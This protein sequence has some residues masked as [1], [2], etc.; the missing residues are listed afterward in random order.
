MTTVRSTAAQ[1]PAPLL[2]ATEKTEDR[3][4]D[5]TE[6]RFAEIDRQR[7]LDSFPTA[8]L[9]ASNGAFQRIMNPGLK[10]IQNDPSAANAVQRPLSTSN[11]KPPLQPQIY[12][13]KQQDVLV[14]SDCGQI[15]DFP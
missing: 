14:F 13:L 7:L 4:D 5:E 1:A 6:R 9:N 11:E 12:D 3:F 15:E 10:E 2:R 8:A